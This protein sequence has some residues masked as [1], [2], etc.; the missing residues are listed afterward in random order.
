MFPIFLKTVKK[1]LKTLAKQP[2]FSH[3]LSLDIWFQKTSKNRAWIT[4]RFNFSLDL[5]NPRMLFS[6]TFHGQT[7]N[8]LEKVPKWFNFNRQDHFLRDFFY[9]DQTSLNIPQR[10]STCSKSWPNESISCRAKNQV[11]NWDVSLGL[12]KPLFSS[13][14]LYWYFPAALE[15]FDNG[16][17]FAPVVWL[18]EKTAKQKLCRGKLWDFQLFWILEN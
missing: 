2:H 9:W 14:M 1:K 16:N 10:H 18:S 3:Y 5:F 13:A 6:A 17:S 12:H 15:S 11:K 8:S 4:K 7:F